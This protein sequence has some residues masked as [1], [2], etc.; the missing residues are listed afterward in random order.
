MAS[1]TA[2]RVNV[3]ALSTAQRKALQALKRPVTDAAARFKVV[4]E[5]LT[6]LAPKVIKLFNEITATSEGFT[7]VE[8]CRL[9]DATIPTHAADRDGEIGYRNHRVYYTL[10]Y[11]RRLVQLTRTGRR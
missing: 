1:D 10:A 6:E 9:F 2:D 5:K 3:N 8:F 11:M 4:R 7:F